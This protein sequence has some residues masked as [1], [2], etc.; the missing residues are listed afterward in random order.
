MGGGTSG[1]VQ[2]YDGSKA[3]WT[4]DEAGNPVNTYGRSKLEAEQVIQVRPQICRSPILPC[5]E[6]QIGGLRSALANIRV[7]PIPQRFMEQCP[8]PAFL[9]PYSRFW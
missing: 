4:E 2:V 1:C 8:C 9:K 7:H 5:V 6:C 3:H